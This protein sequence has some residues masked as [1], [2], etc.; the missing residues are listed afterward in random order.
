MKRRLPGGRNPKGVSCCGE[1]LSN[2]QKCNSLNIHGD[3]SLFLNHVHRPS[4]FLLRK[5]DSTGNPRQPKWHGRKI[6]WEKRIIRQLGIEQI[7]LFFNLSLWTH[8]VHCGKVVNDWE[9]T[10]RKKVIFC[11]SSQW[12]VVW[13]HYLVYE[14]NCCMAHMAKFTGAAETVCWAAAARGFTL[15]GGTG[16]GQQATLLLLWQEDLQTL[17]GLFTPLAWTGV[18]RSH[19]LSQPIFVRSSQSA[20]QHTSRHN[21]NWSYPNTGPS[22][23]LEYH[24]KDQYFVSL[25]SESETHILYRFITHR[26]KYFKPLFLECLMIMAYR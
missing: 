2:S 11:M 4:E 8:V 16:G 22:K 26:V 12:Y 1:A 13:V 6:E 5:R 23:K 15:L 10:C 19:V 24:E 17:P 3:Q 20:Q 18:V 21:P 9:G 25:I 14:S 7:V